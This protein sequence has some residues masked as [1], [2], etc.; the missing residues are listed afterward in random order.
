[1][2]FGRDQRGYFQAQPHE[3]AI[4]T[5][6]ISQAF[7]V[8]IPALLWFLGV[9]VTIPLFAF[10][11]IWVIA[12]VWAHRRIRP[13]ERRHEGDVMV[14]YGQEARRGLRGAYCLYAATIPTNLIALASVAITV[15]PAAMTALAVP[16]LSGWTDQIVTI[17][18]VVY[19]VV[20]LALTGVAVVGMH[21]IRKEIE[22][23]TMA[24]ASPLRY[25]SLAAAKEG[26]VIVGHEFEHV[27]QVP[28]PAWAVG[29][30]VEPL[31]GEIRG[32]TVLLRVGE[33]GPFVIDLEKMRNPHA[34]IVGA[35]GSGKTETVKVLA[36]R[37]W[38]AKQIPSL[39]IDWTGEYAPFIRSLGGVVWRVP[40]D[41]TVNPLKLLGFSPVERAAEV[42]ESLTFSIDLT[43][44]QAAEVGKIASEA[45][46][47]KGITQEDASTWNRPP[48]TIQDIISIMEARVGSGYY[49]GQAVESVNWTIR[50]LYRVLRIFGEEPAEFFDT[51]LRVPTCIDMSP[52]RGVDVAKALVSYTALQRIY[53]QFDVRG[54]TKGLQLLIVLDEAHLILKSGE[55]EK[56]GITQESLPIRIARLG[57][58][59][60]FAEILSS[61]LASDVPEEAAANVGT[62]IALQF[63]EPH[64]VGYVKK[65]INLSKSELEIYA[66]LPRGGTFVKQL[67]ERYPAL[68]KIQRVGS[69]ELAAAKQMTAKL[70][71]TAPP[72]RPQAEPPSKTHEPRAPASDQRVCPHCGQK[73]EVDA[74][75]CD[76]CSE[77]VAPAREA[78]PK[79]SLKDYYERTM[80]Q[81]E[82][83]A[84]EPTA[85]PP[86]TP[87]P[88]KPELPTQELT[89]DELRILRALLRKIG[90]I[91]GIR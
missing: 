28:A 37:Y 91:Q 46:K 1:M 87:P 29:G 71:K 83:P 62:I 61:Q 52:L 58:K 5:F 31:E 12:G 2:S 15:G 81:P 14:A 56:A 48:P 75:F 4:Q 17:I 32:K 38:L 85:E 16:V 3:A 25:D 8:G 63:D 33:D 82:K 34:V 79:E 86:P 57:R 19:G 72:H 36:L 47:E 77:P 66:R 51:V 27:I 26:E 43:A 42:E 13:R 35:S 64:Q 55:E 18:Q 54:L 74:Q 22:A 60:G 30:A 40:E 9:S 84:E 65:W 6:I 67:G 53:Q 80:R 78:P 20:L 69:E 50:K 10:P 73:L 68:V 21:N 59:Y 44:L 7:A 11:F 41:F 76:Y 49:K 89:P 90:A 88:P 45:Y 23:T 70:E 39:I 24:W